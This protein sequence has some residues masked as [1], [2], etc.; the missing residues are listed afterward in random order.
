M[1][2]ELYSHENDR[3]LYTVL[4]EVVYEVVTDT[5]PFNKSA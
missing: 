4:G 2:S 1:H 5:R 3:N